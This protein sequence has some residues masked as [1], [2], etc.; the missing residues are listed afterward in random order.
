MTIEY[1]PF[2]FCSI[3][4]KDFFFFDFKLEKQQWIET[5]KF[6]LIFWLKILIWIEFSRF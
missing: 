5:E 2:I 6:W 3:W 4:I 1:I